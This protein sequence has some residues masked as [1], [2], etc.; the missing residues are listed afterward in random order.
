[1]HLSCPL[2]E[3]KNNNEK[4]EEKEQDKKIKKSDWKPKGI[5]NKGS[6][7]VNKHPLWAHLISTAC[8]ALIDEKKSCFL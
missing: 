6:V 3:N 8:I 4:E 7:L 2:K 1:M 5:E